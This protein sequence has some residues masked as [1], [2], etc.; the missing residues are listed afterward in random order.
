MSGSK[1]ALT[2]LAQRLTPLIRAR[3]FLFLRGRPQ[4]RLAG[5]DEHDLLQL[6]WCKLIED[7]G[8]RLL[9]FD[10]ARGVSLEGFVSVV[11]QRQLIDLT[12]HRSDQ[13]ALA[14]NPWN[15]LRA[16]P[17]GVADDW[18]PAGVGPLYESLGQGS[19]IFRMAMT[20]ATRDARS[21][22]IQLAATATD[23]SPIPT[24][25]NVSGSRGSTLNS[26]D[27]IRRVAATKPSAMTDTML[28]TSI[29]CCRVVIP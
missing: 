2:M 14:F 8:R 3:V 24:A 27:R 21:A 9:S 5:Q 10:P 16:T 26:I 19:L 4:R 28:A 15:L 20:G 22:G 13:E 6:A 18:D 25:P 23:A 29:H 1:S 11:V 12:R 7:G 17:T